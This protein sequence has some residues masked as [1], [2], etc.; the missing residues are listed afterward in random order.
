MS[1]FKLKKD[2]REVFGL[3]AWIFAFFAVV[4]AFGALAVAANALNDSKDAK[5]VAA[6]GGAGSKVTLSEFK[7]DPAMVSVL[8]GRFARGDERR[9]RRSQPGGEG[10]RPQDRD[11]E[12]RRERGARRR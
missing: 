4:L 5:A 9:D 7:I 11:A 6:V 12:A 2:D 8:E 10:H 1:R 3:G